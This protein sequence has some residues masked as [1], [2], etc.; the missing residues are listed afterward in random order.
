MYVWQ[1][2]PI[3]YLGG[4]GRGGRGSPIS[5]AYALH[6]LSIVNGSMCLKKAEIFLGL[7]SFYALTYD[8]STCCRFVGRYPLW[9]FPPNPM[10]LL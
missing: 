1:G 10:G 9:G 5:D 6:A 2:D 8:I 3:V 7:L 4:G